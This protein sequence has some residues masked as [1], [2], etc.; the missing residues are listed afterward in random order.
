MKRWESVPEHAAVGAPNSWRMN[1]PR[2][3]CRR[4]AICMLRES[5]RSTATKF[6]CGTAALTTSTGRNRQNTTHADQRDTQT[7]EH[8]AVARA[9]LTAGGAR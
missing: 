8:D 4:S 1:V 9:Q 6:C 5:S 2:G 3:A 7:G